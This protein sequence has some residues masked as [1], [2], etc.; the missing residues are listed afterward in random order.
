MTEKSL[1]ISVSVRYQHLEVAQATQQLLALHG[2]GQLSL[3]FSR[4]FKVFKEKGIE[5]FVPEARALFYLKRGAGAIGASWMTSKDREAW[6]GE[7]IKYLNQLC[8]QFNQSLP[9]SVLGFSQGAETAARWAVMGDYHVRHLILCGGQLPDDVLKNHDLNRLKQIPVFCFFGKS[10]H[11]FDR[12]KVRLLK[13]KYLALGL[14]CR[15]IEFDGGHELKSDT[16]KKCIPFI[17]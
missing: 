12:E 14:N 11:L 9:L 1:K 7:N 16:L 8:S 2:Y 4:E 17:L 15:F 5:C 13:E 10:D 6:I 3:D